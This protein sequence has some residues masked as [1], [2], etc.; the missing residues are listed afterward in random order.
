MATNND[1]NLNAQGTV[2][3]NGTGTFSGVDGSTAGKVL[4]SNGT[5]VAPSFQTAA[6]GNVTGPGS[7]TDNALV[8]WDGT[9]GT[10]IQNG[11]ITEDDTGNLSVVASVSGG[12]L[13]T[14]VSNTSN[15]ASATAHFDAVVAGGTAADAYFTSTIT[16]GQTWT[17]GGDNSDSDAYVLSAN[18]SLGTTNVMRVQTTGEINYPLQSAFLAHLN[19]D[20]ANAT[21]NGAT[22]TLG[23][24]GTA[25]TEDFDQN[26]DFNTNGTFTAPVTGRYMIGSQIMFK[27]LTSAMTFNVINNRTSNAVYPYGYISAGAVR[28]GVVEANDMSAA[29]CVFA[30]MDAAD[31]FIV[32]V[33]LSGGAGNTATIGGSGSRR[34]N[35]YGYLVC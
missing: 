31:T 1:I 6:T 19:A 7:S 13:S 30:D 25:L 8:R 28:T 34:V 16:G 20:D 24:T 23:T 9:G 11:V 21:G 26:S 10:A 2:Y 14:T 35:M 32:E 3:Y 17:W 27:S 22:Y 15:T 33:Q 12:S 4:T 29:A 18:A 5:G